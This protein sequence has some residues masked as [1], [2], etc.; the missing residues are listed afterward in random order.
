MG[1]FESGAILFA[2]ICISPLASTRHRLL[3]EADDAKGAENPVKLA[4]IDACIAA[5][6]LL[7]L[8]QFAFVAAPCT[9]AAYSSAGSSPP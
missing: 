1:K 5:R 9:R 7:P 2:R 4:Y 3:R 8:V 6:K